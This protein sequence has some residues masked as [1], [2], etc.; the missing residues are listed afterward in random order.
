M[1]LP[2]EP[3]N[4]VT[5]TRRNACT[6]LL[7]L[8]ILPCGCSAYLARVKQTDTLLSGPQVAGRLETLLDAA[9]DK[10]AGAAGVHAVL[11]RQERI[12]GR[13]RPQETLDYLQR[14]HPHSLRTEWIGERN[15]G[16]RV[17]YVQG[18]NDDKVIARPGGLAGLFV[19]ELRLDLDDKLVLQGSRYPPDIAGYNRLVL[20][21]HRAVRELRQRRDVVFRSTGRSTRYGQNRQ[22]FEIVVPKLEPDDEVSRGIIEFDLDASLPV[23][24]LFY[25]REGK[26]R[27]DY[28]W[29]ELELRYDLTDDDFTFGPEGSG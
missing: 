15:K 10:L 24:V 17:I 3:I 4:P 12:D 20:R 7:M 19:K 2:A 22:L 25:D 23:E 16:N 26:L 1:D 21:M 14:F 29:D 6:I 27:E 8:C 9:L 11:T 13:L 28:Q 18:R 5:Q